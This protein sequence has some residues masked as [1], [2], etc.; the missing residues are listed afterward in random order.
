MIVAQC[1]PSEIEEPSGSCE[2][3]SVKWNDEVENYKQVPASVCL[4]RLL[5]AP[6]E[7]IKLGTCSGIERRVCIRT[8]GSSH[9][10]S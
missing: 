3:G 4:A 5:V 1:S 9:E 8:I 10:R 6:L 2:D 7:S